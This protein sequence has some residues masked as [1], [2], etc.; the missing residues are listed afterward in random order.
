MTKKLKEEELRLMAEL[1]YPKK[2]IQLYAD[3]VNLGALKKPDIVTTYLGPC[4][5]FIELHLK[6]GKASIIKNGKFCYVGCP[7]S[8]MS[9]SAMIE[10][11]KGKT[12]DEA[13]K[14][15]EQDI[16]NALGG[17]PTEK[18]DCAKLAITTL[19][20]AIAEYEKI[21]GRSEI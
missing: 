17:L 6:I 10:L 3:K 15:T 9:V 20:K 13:K 18:L 14:I 11:A 7:G 5:D 16:I 1:G 21:R 19:R 12:V 8:A 2:A 4:G